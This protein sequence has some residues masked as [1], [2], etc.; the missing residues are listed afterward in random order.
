MATENLKELLQN[1]IVTFSFTKT[2]GETRE[3]IGTRCLDIATGITE[4]D[5]PKGVKA[6]I[7]GVITFWD[8]EK[9]AWRSCREDSILDIDK[10]VSK[11]DAL[12]IPE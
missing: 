2:N 6:E 10:V 8:C 3:A 5:M 12:N 1:S 11:K 9:Q 4:N 7:P